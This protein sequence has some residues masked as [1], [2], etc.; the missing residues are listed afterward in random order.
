MY[1]REMTEEIGVYSCLVI[2]SVGV[3]QSNNI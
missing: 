2:G 1:Q 3:V